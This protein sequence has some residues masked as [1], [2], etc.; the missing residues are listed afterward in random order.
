MSRDYQEQSQ[1]ETLADKQYNLQEYWQEL[2]DYD[3]GEYDGLSG[4]KCDPDESEEYKRGFADGYEYAQ[5]IGAD[6]NG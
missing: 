5:I 6:I 4:Y 3:R 2:T 1:L